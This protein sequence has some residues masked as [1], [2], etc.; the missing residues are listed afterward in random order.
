MLRIDRREL[1]GGPVETIGE[2]S[3]EDPAFEGLEFALEAPLRVSGTLQP[4]GR[5]AYLWRG[6]L[7]GRVLGE[8]RRCLA[9]VLSPIDAVVDVL[10]SVDPDAADDPSVY[11]LADEATHVDLRPA[12]REELAL[13]VSPLVLC[14]EECRGLCPR[15]GGDLN[16]GACTCRPAEPS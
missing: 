10:F 12:V 14:R 8:C 13:A 2:L 11:A 1:R 7:E 4:T 3:A 15:C 5:G 9:D 6:R 16:A